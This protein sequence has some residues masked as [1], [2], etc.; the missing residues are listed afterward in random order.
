MPKIIAAADKQIGEMIAKRRRALGLTQDQLAERL[1]M[2]REAYSRLELGKTS[3][4]VPKLIQLANVLDCGL[5]ELV[6]DFS[7]R[8]GDQ[9]HKLGLLLAPLPDVDRQFVLASTEHLI[10]HLKNR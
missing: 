5:A 3:L 1:S 6:T 7:P 8:P 4:S 9:G 10:A 2:G